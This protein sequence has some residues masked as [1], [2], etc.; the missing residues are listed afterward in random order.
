MSVRPIY[1]YNAL[2]HHLEALKA[3][4]ASLD[5]DYLVQPFT[6]AP[7]QGGRVLAFREHPPFICDSLLVENPAM[8]VDALLWALEKKALPH[9]GYA[10]KLIRWMGKE[11]KEVQ[12][13]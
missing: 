12:D 1:L 4:K 11:V 7:G 10:D 13:G 5:L 2:P 8:T 3:A 6:A 9:D